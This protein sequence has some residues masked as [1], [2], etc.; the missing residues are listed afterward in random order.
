[1]PEP[2]KK[3]QA[4][5]KAKRETKAKTTPKAPKE[6]RGDEKIVEQLLEEAKLNGCTWANLALA[7]Q[8]C[9][10][11]PSKSG[12]G[13]RTVLFCVHRRFPW[14]PGEALRPV[15]YRHIGNHGSS[16]GVVLL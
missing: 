6:A 14:H 2:K 15:G 5:R 9:E 10:N 3:R 7:K 13:G 8:A 1:M 16:N 12:L 11:F 4:K